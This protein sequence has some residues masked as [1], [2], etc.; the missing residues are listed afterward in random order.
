MP[1]FLFDEEYRLAVGSEELELCEDDRLVDERQIDFVCFEHVRLAGLKHFLL[2]VHDQ[3][4]W[5]SGHVDIDGQGVLSHNFDDDGNI[6]TA[7]LFGND[8]KVQLV[9][10]TGSN[11]S[12]DLD[13]L[14]IAS[15]FELSSWG[16]TKNLVG[17]LRL[18]VH[19]NS[20]GVGVFNVHLA[21]L[22]WIARSDFD[23]GH[24]DFCFDSDGGHV[25]TLMTNVEHKR[26]V[27]YDGLRGSEGQIE[28]ARFM[29]LDSSD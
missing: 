5:V 25:L 4:L 11:S 20:L 22:E 29:R 12:R 3:A 23:V 18:V 19:E 27:L 26:G 1:L 7:C 8:F 15:I 21:L 17:R 13:G 2:V 6:D 14:V 16:S 24:D 28:H 10:L 9:V